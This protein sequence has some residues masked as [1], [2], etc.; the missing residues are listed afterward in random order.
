M[1]TYKYLGVEER[2][3]PAAGITVK[4][5]DTFEVE[6]DVAKGLDGQPLFER[7][8]AGKP[9]DTKSAPDAGRE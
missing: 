2:E 5:G 9:V 8:K 3:I 1:V 4:R 7:V 6:S